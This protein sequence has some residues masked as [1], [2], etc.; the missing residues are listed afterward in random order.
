MS[1]SL[2]DVLIG[3]SLSPESDRVV[4]SG[5]GIARAAGARV[6]LIHAFSL[7]MSYV[8]SPFY[9]EAIPMAELTEMERKAQAAAL[10]AQC[11][12][13]RGGANLASSHLEA[14]P[15]HQILI[16][17]ARE[18]GADLIVV[19]TSESPALARFFGSTADRVIRRAT[20][21]VLVLCRELALPLQRVLFPVDLSPLSADALSAGLAFLAGLGDAGKATL[22]A[23]MVLAEP[24]LENLSRWQ[25]TSTVER[26]VREQLEV[27]VAQGASGAGRGFS[28]RVDSGLVGEEVV[29]RIEDWRPDLVVMG[30]HGR[31]G[32]E[33]LLLGSVTADVLRRGGANVLVVPPEPAR[34][35]APELEPRRHVENHPRPGSV[36]A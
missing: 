12:R 9:P 19:G 23:Q 36:A 17:T 13:L 29:D 18:V 26:R 28:L 24:D 30:T 34:Q 8:G 35:G 14:G 4:A 6:H 21:P 11:E 32:F 20:V 15:A 7:P 33:R 22:E 27:F 1:S 10:A 2:H 25:E 5:L 3:T 16:E 31:G